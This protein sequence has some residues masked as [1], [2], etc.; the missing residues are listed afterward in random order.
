MISSFSTSTI[1]VNLAKAHGVTPPVFLHMDSRLLYLE[2]D[3]KN[4]NNYSMGFQEAQR[5]IHD[6]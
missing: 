6:H 5:E 2:S 4:H 3:T 1:C